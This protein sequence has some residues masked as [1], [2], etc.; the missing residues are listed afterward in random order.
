MSDYLF[1]GPSLSPAEATELLPGVTVLPP[2]RHGDLFRVDAG[3][4][5]RVLIVDGFFL[6]TAPVRHK[7]ILGTLAAGAVVAGAGSMGALRAAELWPYG[8]RGVGAVFELYRDGVV[9]GDD[10]VAVVHAPQE[11]GYR[12]LSEPLVNIRLSLR[13]AAESHAMTV[14]ATE[15]VLAAARALPFRARSLRALQR[16]AAGAH[17]AA[18]DI[19]TFLDWHRRRRPD[20][21]ASDARALL[22]AAAAGSLA[23]HGPGDAPIDNVGTGNQRRWWLEQSRPA[24]DGVSRLDLVLA[25]M[26]LHPEYPALLR[27]AVLASLTGLAPGDPDLTTRAVAWL[28]EHGLMTGFDADWLSMAERRVLDPAAGALT[29]MV[30]AGGAW[31]LPELSPPPFADRLDRP[32]LWRAAARVVELAGRANAWLPTTG[33]ARRLHFRPEVVDACFARLWGCEPA[34]IDSAARDRGFPTPSLYRRHAERYVALL[35]TGGPGPLPPLLGLAATA[36]AER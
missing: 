2:I 26:L 28:R 24:A 3:E 10:E 6:H 34:E 21:K 17:P 9:T 31:R 19:R 11:D 23:P 33:G 14:A 22:A 16:L 15:R 1:L 13:A 4:G 8:M 36:P 29:A 18:D 32:E 30:R 7:E 35:K 5:D 12:S 20:A 27:R 25:I